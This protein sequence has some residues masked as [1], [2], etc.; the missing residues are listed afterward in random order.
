[1]REFVG[2]IAITLFYLA[3]SAQV[4]PS[5]MPISDPAVRSAIDYYYQ[6]IAENSHL[7]NGRE[8]AG[9]NVNLIGNPFFDT[10]AL[11]PGWVR[12]DGI[13][14]TNV[15]LQL[16]VHD[17]VLITNKYHQD[18]KIM[19][20]TEKIDSFSVLSH[21]YIRMAPIGSKPAAAAPLFYDRV[22]S[23]QTTVFVLRKK[24]TK[25]DPV[26]NGEIKSRY[27]K[28]DEYYV[29]ENN[30][31]YQVRGEKSLLKLFGDR[32]KELKRFMRKNKL[33]FRKR[34]EAAITAAVAYFDQSI[35]KI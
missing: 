4:V 27:I 34:P 7:N 9:Y 12:F 15:P 25:D 17:G 31:F 30:S 11:T 19:L 10:T 13:L 23:G 3:S 14:Y 18:L 16:D 29:Q 20:P 33:N 26:V 32:Q 2:C 28:A 21:T 5:A 24:I 8:Y 35:R 6:N 22:Y 1:M